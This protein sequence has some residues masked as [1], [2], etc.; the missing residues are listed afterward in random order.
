MEIADKNV[1]FLKKKLIFLGVFSYIFWQNDFSVPYLRT[2][3]LQ[4]LVT[5]Y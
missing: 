5:E 1:F 2:G 4:K 3:I